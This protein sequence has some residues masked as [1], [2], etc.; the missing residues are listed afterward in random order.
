VTPAKTGSAPAF[1]NNTPMHHAEVHSMASEKSVV[2]IPPPMFCEKPFEFGDT[3]TVFEASM[4][5][6]GRHPHGQFLKGANVN[7]HLK[8]LRAGI[9]EQP[10]SR[11]RA[12]ARRSWDIYCAL[13]DRIKDGI[14]VPARISY[15][16][17]G[18]IDPIRTLIRTRHLVDLARDRGEHPK[19]LRH[20]LVENSR[21]AA[22][23]ATLK[24]G[25]CPGQD[26]GWPWQKFC[27][28]IRD[29]ADGWTDRH[30]GLCKRGF[31][32]KVIERA[33]RRL[34]QQSR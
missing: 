17:S 21:E 7:D 20:L 18:E 10:R 1:R 5:Y 25:A 26:P 16:Q 3:L 15:Q 24:N 32:N 4:V 9:P 6:A 13:I 19:Y 22:I 8:F 33:A 23:A 27:D 30:N 34:M 12:R 2:S 14:I 28:I 11:V 29:Q 31:S